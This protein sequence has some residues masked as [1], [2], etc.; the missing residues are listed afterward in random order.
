MAAVVYY[1]VIPF[2]YLV[3]LLPF[4][5]LYLLSDFLFFVFYR[6]VG[7]RKDIVLQNL[8]NSFPERSAEELEKIRRDF[9][10]YFCDLLLETFK[11]LTI[12]KKEM[13][14]RCSFH[15]EALAL[16]QGLAEQHKSCIMVL[17]HYGNWEWGGNTFSML[18]RH[19]LYVIYH[20]LT[21]KYFDG[22]MYRMRTRFGTR[23]IAMK[24][25]Y[26]EIY[27]RK[28]ELATTAFIADQTPRPDNAFWLTFLNQD[29]PVFKGTGTISKKLGFPI[30]YTTVDRT[31]R[32]YYQI[33]A[34]L[35]CADASAYTEEEITRMHTA[36]LEADIR[37]K[38]EIW[39]W[40]H[41]RW[42]H[43]RPADVKS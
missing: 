5:L 8:R 4:P 29:T 31:A 15:P 25:A 38:P 35:L 7:Y 33:C 32:G 2:I 36:A 13:L 16:Y 24:Q 14:R 41:R 20:P 21:N 40:S 28:G 22:L 23:L 3:S 34:R 6:L 1:L 11:T 42:K 27:L 43:K 17:G 26:K 37:N 10:R 39:L 30:V 19:Q 12:S 18:A 9:Y